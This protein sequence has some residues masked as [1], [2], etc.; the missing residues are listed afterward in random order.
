[1]L[2]VLVALNVLL[3]VALAGRMGGENTAQAQ[4][5]QRRRVGEFIMIPGKVSG[6]ANSVMYFIDTNNNVLGAMAYDDSR[7]VINSMEP[8]DLNRIFQV[9]VDDQ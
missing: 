6:G 5:G 7:Q 1:M 2:W 4:V 8:I 3:L 9:E